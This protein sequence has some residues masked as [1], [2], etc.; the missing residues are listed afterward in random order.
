MHKE[1]DMISASDPGIV[2]P[3]EFSS[4]RGPQFCSSDP[5]ISNPGLGEMTAPDDRPWH[6]SAAVAAWPV[7]FA[8]AAA[9]GKPAYCESVAP[10]L[11]SRPSSMALSSD[12]DVPSWILARTR[13]S[14]AAS[15]AATCPTE[16]SLVPLGAFQ[17]SSWSHGSSV[18]AGREALARLV[19][20]LVDAISCLNDPIGSEPVRGLSLWS[21]RSALPTPFLTNVQDTLFRSAIWHRPNAELLRGHSRNEWLIRS[22]SCMD[23][24]CLVLGNSEAIAVLISGKVAFTLSRF[25]CHCCFRKGLVWQPDNL[26]L[27]IGN[28]AIITAWFAV[29]SIGPTGIERRLDDRRR[30]AQIGTENFTFGWFAFGKPGSHELSVPRIQNI[31]RFDVT[32]HVF[33]QDGFDWLGRQFR[34]WR[35]ILVFIGHDSD[36]S[37][38]CLVRRQNLCGQVPHYFLLAKLQNGCSDDHWLRGGSAEG[39]H[40]DD[41][42]LAWD[43]RIIVF[44]NQEA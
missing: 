39:R 8:A 9:N 7:C 18:P 1:T 14:T 34:P 24:L 38:G 44:Q 21:Q 17:G 20:V 27:F 3:Q 33:L 5:T 16:I 23:L 13:F 40:L 35:W 2:T 28:A 22:V 41:L 36:H 30:Q 12:L 32:E 43:S 31:L 15:M 29:N 4:W 26:V 42:L 10:T 25:L 11:A 6:R 19:S 37:I